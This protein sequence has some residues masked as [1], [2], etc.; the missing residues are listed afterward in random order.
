MSAPIKPTEKTKPTNL[1]LHDFPYDSFIMGVYIPDKVCDDLVN[2]FESNP[3]KQYKGTVNAN[4]NNNKN[5]MIENY[6]AEVLD[7]GRVRFSSDEFK[8]STDMGFEPIKFKEDHD[9][10]NDYFFYLNQAIQEYEHLYENCK[11]LES[12]GTAEG[13][14]IQK[15]EP[16]GGFY[17]WHQ[18]RNGTATQTRCFVHMTYLNDVENGG[19]EFYYQKLTSPAKKGLTLIW[20]ADW[21]HLHRGQISYTDTKYIITG[22]L[23][24]RG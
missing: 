6:G 16:G 14:N 3:E 8:K 5:T 17:Q 15:Y 23:N 24:Y 9:I 19:T 4:P 7:N 11:D 1:K 2:H 21:T 20:P 22:W 18:E 12:Y 13:I 10:L